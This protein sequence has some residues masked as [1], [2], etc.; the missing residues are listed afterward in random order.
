MGL[1]K[2]FYWLILVKPIFFSSFQRLWEPSGFSSFKAKTNIVTQTKSLQ[3]KK[4][5]LLL[6]L[7]CLWPCFN[8]VDGQY[9][10][11]AKVPHPSLSMKSCSLPFGGKKVV[12]SLKTNLEKIGKIKEWFNVPR[13]DDPSQALFSL[14]NWG[15]SP[16]STP[17]WMHNF[18][19]FVIRGKNKEFLNVCASYGG[20]PPTASVSDL[21]KLLSQINSTYQIIRLEFCGPD[22]CFYNGPRV[23][24]WL[25]TATETTG[26]LKSG[27]TSSFI[28]QLSTIS[29]IT[30]SS[31]LLSSLD[32]SKYDE[33]ST[34]ICVVPKNGRMAFFANPFDHTHHTTTATN[35][36]DMLYKS[37]DSYLDK[38]RLT[39]LDLSHE[40]SD[41]ATV[42]FPHF[43]RA[44]VELLNAMES[45]VWGQSCGHFESV[46]L[47]KTKDLVRVISAS[48]VK[49]GLGYIEVGGATCEI[50]VSKHLGC[51]C[52]D[53][54]EKYQEVLIEPTEFQGRILSF[55]SFV[56]RVI[57]QG[58]NPAVSESCYYA[59]RN[60]F[61]ILTNKC[62]AELI[63]ASNLA[64]NHCPSYLVVNFS[65]LSLDKQLFTVDDT[66]TY[67]L[68]TKCENAIV[69]DAKPGDALKLTSCSLSLWDSIGN[70]LLRS[71]GTF[72][73]EKKLNKIIPS[74]D[75]ATKDIILYSVVSVLGFVLLLILVVI[76]FYC[77]PGLGHHVGRHCFRRNDQVLEPMS[78]RVSDRLADYELQ[79]LRLKPIMQ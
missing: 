67:D 69:N 48:S 68:Q 41:L 31:N 33:V 71:F 61:F 70:Y 52:A 11:V 34:Q 5:T 55:D 17:E 4:M 66:N 57:N 78:H 47:T 18:Y 35:A 20:H 38:L 1:L 44:L 7:L 28:K 27:A 79:S 51:I 75:I 12:D 19:P 29:I 37:V 64:V 53:S 25:D 60:K 58:S 21:P 42:A 13:Y 22:L 77:N 50:S 24:N 30:P 72:N 46:L 14:P 62:C 63:S 6:L 65:P 9:N 15:L 32:K 10:L 8:R 45:C 39:S 43:M 16:A 76:V 40:G 54:D 2:K 59:S 23:T 26:E 74:N 49:L 36:L 56:H 73:S 3:K